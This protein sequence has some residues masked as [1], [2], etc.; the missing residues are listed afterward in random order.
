MPQD[1]SYARVDRCPP[2]DAK[3]HLARL[4]AGMRARGKREAVLGMPLAKHELLLDRKVPCS[5][6][7]VRCGGRPGWVQVGVAEKGEASL[8]GLRH[9]EVEQ[10]SKRVG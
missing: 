2:A 6:T 8:G 4:S 5:L 7:M 1:A 3:G 9:G 10:R